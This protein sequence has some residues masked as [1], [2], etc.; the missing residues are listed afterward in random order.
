MKQ[1]L[2]EGLVGE[3]SK[4]TREVLMANERLENKL[5]T[6]NSDLNLFG[7]YPLVHG[8]V[9][10][11]Q[12]MKEKI[13]DYKEEKITLLDSALS[14]RIEKVDRIVAMNRMKSVSLTQLAKL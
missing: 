13:R 6:I 8:Y 14:L 12:S 9:N 3:A 10:H 4:V 5:K 11:L 1:L 2:S 7:D